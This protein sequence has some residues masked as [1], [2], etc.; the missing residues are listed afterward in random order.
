VHH[1]ADVGR[2]LL[3]LGSGQH[4]AVVERVQKALLGDPA[5]P[6]DQVLVHDR[7]LPGRAAEADEAE[8]EP[9]AK[10]L[11]KADGAGGC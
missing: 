10:C 1:P 8:L 11:A 3:R 4:H 5:F 6:L 7:D 9:V 2:E